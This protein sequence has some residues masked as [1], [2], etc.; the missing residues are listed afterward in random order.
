MDGDERPTNDEI[1]RSMQPDGTLDFD[2]ATYALTGLQSMLASAK[3]PFEMLAALYRAGFNS[4]NMVIEDLAHLVAG[5]Q[6][7][8]PGTIN[9]PSC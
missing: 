9:Q 2:G 7:E 6:Y 5:S 8:F 4:P 3:D 1:R